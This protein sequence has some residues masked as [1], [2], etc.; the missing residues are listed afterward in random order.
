M[1]LVHRNMKYCNMAQAMKFSDG[2][3]VLAVLHRHSA[4]SSFYLKKVLEALVEASYPG[5]EIS[6]IT[7]TCLYQ[8]LPKNFNSYFTY[9]GSLTTPPCAESVTWIVFTNFLEAS[10]KDVSFSIISLKRRR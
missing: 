10:R 2:I 8:F 6:I 7:S 3:A 1:H 9:E 4:K 5:T